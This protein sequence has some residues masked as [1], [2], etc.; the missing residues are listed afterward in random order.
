MDWIQSLRIGAAEELLSTVGIALLVGSA[1]GQTRRDARAITWL[2]V[3]TLIGA[4]VITAPALWH[5][6]RGAEAL[7]F[8]GLLSGDAFAAFAKLL[9]YLAAAA[10]LLVAPA[11]F[12]KYRAMRSEY[13]VLVLFAV[14]GMGIMVSATNMLRSTSGSNSIHC[15]PMC[16]RPSSR[17]T[18]VRPRRGS[19][20]SCSAR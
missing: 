9:I 10:S 8:N 3:L 5:G 18:N 1:W 6:V 11:F 7:A 4:A 13:P 15:R 17:P 16:S 12:E 20:I 2:A 14:L 19:S